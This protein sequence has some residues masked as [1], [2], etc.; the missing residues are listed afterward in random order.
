MI[1]FLSAIPAIG[2]LVGRVFGNKE[3]REQAEHSENMSI[4]GQFANEFKDGNRTWFD[5]LIDGLNRL[6]RPFLALGVLGLLAFAPYDPVKFAEIMNVYQLVPPWLAALFAVIVGFYFG[7]RHLEKRL[8]FT[9]VDADKI[10]AVMDANRELKKLRPAI[11]NSQYE[12]ELSDTEKPLSNAAILEW[13]QRR[14]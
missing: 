12:K 13:N 1:Q 3:K 6:P 7:A 14:K 10:R 5:S 9:G 11:S 4:L 2:N 8:K